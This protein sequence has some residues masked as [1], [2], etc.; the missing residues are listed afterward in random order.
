MYKDRTKEKMLYFFVFTIYKFANT[1]VLQ[2]LSFF[3][4]SSFLL[5]ALLRLIFMSLHIFFHLNCF[6][7]VAGKYIF[8][9]YTWIQFCLWIFII[10]VYMNEY[11]QY[12]T[13]ESTLFQIF[14]MFL[15]PNIV[16]IECGWWYSLLFVIFLMIEKISTYR[17][18]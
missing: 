18:I 1:S 17:L 10:S 14:F 5:C 9:G 13:T 8:S 11:L 12:S 6:T 3:T 16:S 2:T 7:G 4:I 15:Y